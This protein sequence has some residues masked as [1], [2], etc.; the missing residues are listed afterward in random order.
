MFDENGNATETTV[1]TVYGYDLTTG[2]FTGSY[3]TRVLEGTGIPAASTLTAPRTTKSSAVSV[4]DGSKWKSVPD[5]RGRTIYSTTDG[6]RFEMRVSGALPDGYT[7]L[8]PVT[9]YD[10]WDGAAWV[11]N[12]GDKK[13]GDVRDAEALMTSLI[14]EANGITQAWQ[15][16]LMLGIITNGDRASLTK[17]MQYIQDVQ[18]VDVSTAPDI[19]WPVKPE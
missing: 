18:A 9:P 11:T 7:L 6:S 12:A 17:W 14:E 19:S 2:E 15:T 4:F 5:Y 3:E 1:I 10:E 13:N 8:S 16:Q